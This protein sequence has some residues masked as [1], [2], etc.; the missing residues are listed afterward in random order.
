MLLQWK[1]WS[2]KKAEQYFWYR[3]S[4]R[5]LVKRSIQPHNIPLNQ[6]LFQSKALS[7]ILWKLSDLEEAAEDKLETTRGWFM[8]FQETSH[9]HNINV[10]SEA[11]S[12]PDLAKI[13]NAHG[14]SKQQISM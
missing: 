11:A 2:V 1:I 4:F 9:L 10:Q 13:I 5:D 7:S 12:Y 8:R 6:S 3:G 14:Y